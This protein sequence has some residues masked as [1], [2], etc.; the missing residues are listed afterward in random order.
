M[1]GRRSHPRYAV[2]EPWEG[3]LR[4][5]RDV[6]VDRVGAD[7]LLAVSH[8]PGIVGEEMSLDLLG[9]GE[10]LRLRVHVI[11]SRPIVVD[12]AVRHRIRL[13][14]VGAAAQFPSPD[15]SQAAPVEAAN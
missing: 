15:L 2:A 8:A 5:L 12:G 14:L 3:T 13:A 9:A 4:V 11:E 10:S 6:I 1:S 7:E